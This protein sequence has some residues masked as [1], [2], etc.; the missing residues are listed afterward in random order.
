MNLIVNIECAFG[1]PAPDKYIKFLI[2]ELD[3]RNNTDIQLCKKYQGSWF[4]LLTN[5]NKEV[6][7][8]K[9]KDIAMY[10]NDLHNKGYVQYFYIGEL[11][12]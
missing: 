2:N 7:E 4:W 11:N 1:L 3:I 10:F 5:I 9:T 12:K 6:Y 8:S